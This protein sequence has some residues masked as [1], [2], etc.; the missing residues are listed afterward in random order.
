MTR[1][2]HKP[3]LQRRFTQY[4]NYTYGTTTSTPGHQEAE[5]PRPDQALHTFEPLALAIF[6]SAIN[7]L[8]AENVMLQFV[9]D[10]ETL[11]AKFQRGVELGLGRENF[12]VTPSIEVLQAFVLLLVS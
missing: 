10:K 7:S 1:L 12:L 9:A 5:T 8:S 11:L 3:T 2:F 4:I 6:Y